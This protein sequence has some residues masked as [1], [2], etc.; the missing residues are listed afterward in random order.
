MV[1]NKTICR[2]YAQAVIAENMA[3]FLTYASAFSRR[4]SAE[5]LHRA[6]VS[7]RRINNLLTIFH[8]VLA[9]HDLKAW[10]KPI[11][12]AGKALGKSRDLDVWIHLL[13]SSFP[14]ILSSHKAAG[15][16]MIV[17]LEKKRQREQAYAQSILARL[18]QSKIIKKA[19]I[20]LGPKPHYPHNDKSLWNMGKQKVGKRLKRFLALSACVSHPQK[21]KQLHRMRIK[22]KKLRYT[23]ESFERVFGARTKY[24]YNTVYAM[25]TALGELHDAE[26]LVVFLQDMKKKKASKEARA[27]LDYLSDF[28]TAIRLVSYKN[29]L[30]LWKESNKKK[31]WNKLRSF[32]KGS[33]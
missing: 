7:L 17:S 26:T 10:R 29:F 12:F 31:F 16:A 19:M 25:Q 11:A 3:E 27:T 33:L 15:K 6:R 22:G 28:F 13:K 2:F 9:P 8:D 5:S 4:P 24:F 30:K 23:L 21:G 1:D 14:K 20:A 32:I 18:A